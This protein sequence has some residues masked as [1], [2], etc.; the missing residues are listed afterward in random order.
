MRGGWS[1]IKE[2]F[3]GSTHVRLRSREEKVNDSNTEYKHIKYK[4][5]SYFAHNIL[6]KNSF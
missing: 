2:S 6:N 3:V 5:I 4:N 1:Y